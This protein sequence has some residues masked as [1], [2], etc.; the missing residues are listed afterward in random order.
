MSAEFKETET[1]GRTNEAIVSD[2][3]ANS[4]QGGKQI[5]LE[6][7]DLIKVIGSFNLNI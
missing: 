6:Q 7:F 5:G 3:G 1:T 2:T 4:S